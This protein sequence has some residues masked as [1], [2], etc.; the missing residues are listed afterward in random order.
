MKITDFRF[1]CTLFRLIS[2]PGI[3]RECE[4]VGSS[5][6]GD[7]KTVGKQCKEVEHIFL[8]LWRNQWKIPWFW[9]LQDFPV[10]TNFV[11]Y[12]RLY[13][14]VYYMRLYVLVYYMRLYVLGFSKSTASTNVL[15]STMATYI[16]NVDI[17]RFWNR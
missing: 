4:P 7:P 12:M 6:C 1:Q 14:L 13:V 16:F 11:Y 10:N 17:A 5:C 2:N 9:E 8:D 15:C 3:K